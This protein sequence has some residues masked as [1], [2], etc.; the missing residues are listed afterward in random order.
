MN[1][2]YRVSLVVS[3]VIFLAYGIH[4]L[5]LGG[6]VADFERFGLSRIRRLTG[7]LEM[8]GALGL[9][10]GMF[11]PVLIGLSAF[12]LATLMLFGI[13]ARIRARDAFAESV[14]A[15]ALLVLNMFVM[16][17]AWGFRGAA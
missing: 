14:P 10:A 1:I 7:A 12:A 4:L 2:A 13:A 5:F 6:M 16:A 11:V 15:L 8:L 3:I 9:I 17:Y